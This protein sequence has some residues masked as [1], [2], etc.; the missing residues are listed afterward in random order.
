M[1]RIPYEFFEFIDLINGF[2]VRNLAK[3]WLTGNKDL[4]I[5]LLPTVKKIIINDENS[6]CELPFS[7]ILNFISKFDIETFDEQL[8]KISCKPEGFEFSN[9]PTNLINL[10]LNS[11]SYIKNFDLSLLPKSI[12]MLS[13]YVKSLINQPSKAFP[14]KIN[15]FSLQS[16]YFSESKES[17]EN[18][19]VSLKVLKIEKFQL[20]ENFLQNILHLINVRELFVKSI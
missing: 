14:Q 20:N 15:Y 12:K 9:L 5:N 1:L 11:I 2:S 6:K 8:F 13:I 10:R 16:Y 17:L 3:L 4:Q 19:P 18:L 7:L